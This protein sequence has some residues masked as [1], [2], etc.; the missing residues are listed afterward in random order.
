MC[1]R[2]TATGANLGGGCKGCTLPPCND[3]RLSNTTGILHRKKLWFICVEEKRDMRLK[4]L[5][6]MVHP[7]VRKILNPLL[8]CYAGEL[9]CRRKSCPLLPLPG[10]KF[11]F[12]KCSFKV[13]DSTGFF[14]CFL[15]GR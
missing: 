1:L 2:L 7:L 14:K 13:A 6:K 12:S 3:L 8:L 4:N 10:G 15:S 9:K 11:I 5:C